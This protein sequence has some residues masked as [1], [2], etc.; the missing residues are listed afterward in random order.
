M[1]AGVHEW[2]QITH[3]ER[4]WLNMVAARTN[5][6]ALTIGSLQRWCEQ[7]LVSE[8]GITGVRTVESQWND[9]GEPIG[10]EIRISYRFARMVQAVATE[11]AAARNAAIDVELEKW[12]SRGMG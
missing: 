8:L 10:P 9:D 11:V 3:D 12:P 6:D 5:L 1:S 2:D 7:Q 4:D